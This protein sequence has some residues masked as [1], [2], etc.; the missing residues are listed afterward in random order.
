MTCTMATFPA[1]FGAFV[2]Q[3]PYNLPPVPV[4]GWLSVEI[5]STLI[6]PSN[7]VV[8]YSMLYD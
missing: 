6:G 4:G 2:G 3:C 5:N 8:T 7:L 1:S